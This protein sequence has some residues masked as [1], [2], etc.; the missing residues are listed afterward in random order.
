MSNE[1]LK[2]IGD[3]YKKLQSK[4]EQIDKSNINMFNMINSKLESIETNLTK[5]KEKSVEFQ[6]AN[7]LNLFKSTETEEKEAVKQLT[8]Q[9]SN[10]KEVNKDVINKNVLPTV[11]TLQTKPINKIKKVEKFNKSQMFQIC[12]EEIDDCD[13]NK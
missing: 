12:E 11:R 13:I 7:D 5:Q 4:I 1:F 8:V 9:K 10:V 6:Y 3:S 2:M